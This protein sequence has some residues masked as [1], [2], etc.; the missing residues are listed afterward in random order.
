MAGIS[1]GL[2]L[3]I[4]LVSRQLFLD[5]PRDAHLRRDRDSPVRSA[6]DN[7]LSLPRLVPRP[8]WTAA[9]LD[10]R[11]PQSTEPARTG[12]YAVLVGRRGDG[13]RLHHRISLGPAGHYA[14]RQHSALAPGDGYRRLWNFVR[15]RIG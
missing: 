14:N 12:V 11:A 8:F 13:T 10:R 3:R 1:I 7:V 6:A 4:H 9:G 5:L 2:C 15:D